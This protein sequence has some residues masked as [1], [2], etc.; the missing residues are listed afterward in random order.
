MSDKLFYAGGQQS[1]EWD[2]PFKDVGSLLLAARMRR[3]DLPGVYVRKGRKSEK[4][5]RAVTGC[6]WEVSDNEPEYVD[7][8]TSYELLEK[9]ASCNLTRLTDNLRLLAGC[10]VS[11]RGPAAEKVQRALD[12]LA[13]I[14]RR[15]KDHDENKAPMTVSTMTYSVNTGFDL[16]TRE[17]AFCGGKG[18]GVFS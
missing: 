18:K 15:K 17:E 16:Y 9:M 8:E 13:D 4:D 7:F 3:P 14:R 11:E 6:A 2:G 5:E 12:Y 10:P 1:E